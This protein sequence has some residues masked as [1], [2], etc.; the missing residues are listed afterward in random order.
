MEARDYGKTSAQNTKFSALNRAFRKLLAVMCDIYLVLAGFFDS[1]TKTFAR[2]LRCEYWESTHR[3]IFVHSL[4]WREQMPLEFA[5]NLSGLL[6]T[7][8]Q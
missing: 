3:T 2:I 1:V 4:L 6:S 8:M 7:N 5:P